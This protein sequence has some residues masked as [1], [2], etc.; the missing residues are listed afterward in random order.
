ML[1]FEY[2]HVSNFVSCADLTSATERNLNGILP[3]AITSKAELGEAQKELK[4]LNDAYSYLSTLG[5]AQQ[6]NERISELRNAINT[7]QQR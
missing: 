5:S 1:G 6:I 2:W 7:F 3:F 4:A